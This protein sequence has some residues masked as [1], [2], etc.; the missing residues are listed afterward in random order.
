MKRFNKI[1]VLIVGIVFVGNLKASI[2]DVFEYGT[3]KTFAFGVCNNHNGSGTISGGGKY[4]NGDNGTD[5]AIFLTYLNS[6]G[7]FT[8]ATKTIKKP[9]PLDPPT[10]Y[11][12]YSV[13]RIKQIS[14]SRYILCGIEEDGRWQGVQ[15]AFACILDQNLNVIKCKSYQGRLSHA[16]DVVE[17]NGGYILVGD[18]NVGNIAK[19][20]AIKLDNN[21]NFVE[22]LHPALSGVKNSYFLSIIEYNNRFYLCGKYQPSYSDNLDVLI[23]RYNK[24]TKNYDMGVYDYRGYDDEGWCINVVPNNPKPFVIAGFGTYTA[25]VDEDFLLFRF[26]DYL[27]IVAKNW[28]GTPGYSANKDRLKFVN[29]V[30]NNL[31]V[32]GFYNYVKP[33]TTQKIARTFIGKISSDFDSG[34]DPYFEWW[35]ADLWTKYNMDHESVCSTVLPYFSTWRVECIGT[36][37]YYSIPSNFGISS[38][39]LTYMP[40]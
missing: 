26:D 28:G 31:F 30:N 34:Y 9:Y 7:S 35:G 19:A 1:V 22:T 39:N 2:I 14:S 10:K 4:Y 11:Y 33:G 18:Y 40:F 27:N 20:G 29:V 21:L 12:S 17:T 24:N 13:M 3:K 25:G 36:S 32:T 37:N 15:R 8:G 16:Y 6:D 5:I 23:A 38:V